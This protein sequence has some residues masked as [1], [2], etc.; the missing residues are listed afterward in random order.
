MAQPHRHVCLRLV[1]ADLQLGY[2]RPEQIE[3]LRQRLAVEH[4]RADIVRPLVNS[5]VH[6]PVLG[7]K[8]AAAQPCRQGRGDRRSEEHTSEHPSLMRISYAVISLKKK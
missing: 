4:Q 2:W 7:I 5:E 8:A 3:R 1:G 6:P